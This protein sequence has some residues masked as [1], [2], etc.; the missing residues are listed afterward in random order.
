MGIILAKST[1]IVMA[2]RWAYCG[3]VF[4]CSLDGSFGWTCGGEIEMTR[5]VLSQGLFGSHAAV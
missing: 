4:T 5:L 1:V 2:G 3:R